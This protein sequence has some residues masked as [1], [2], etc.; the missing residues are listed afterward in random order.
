MK[1][2]IKKLSGRPKDGD[3]VECI[4]PFIVIPTFLLAFIL[5][6]WSIKLNFIGFGIMSMLF[7]WQIGWGMSIERFKKSDKK[8]GV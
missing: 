1:K 5:M 7:S 2:Y 3:I 4:R 6:Y 8:D